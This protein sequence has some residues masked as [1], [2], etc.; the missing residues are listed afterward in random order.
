M[1][2]DQLQPT[3][4]WLVRR[5]RVLHRLLQHLR[6]QRHQARIR[7]YAEYHG[8]IQDYHDLDYQSWTRLG[9]PRLAVF[10]VAGR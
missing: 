8:Y 4:P 1:T 3:R 2:P 7:H 10:H 9:D 6:S 5:R